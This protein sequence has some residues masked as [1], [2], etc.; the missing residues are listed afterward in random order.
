V[1]LSN[2]MR[3]RNSI[4]FVSIDFDSIRLTS[5]RFGSKSSKSS[6]KRNRI[7]NFF[8]IFFQIFMIRFGRIE[9]AIYLNS[10]RFNRFNAKESLS[11]SVEILPSVWFDSIRF[12]S[13]RFDSIR[14]DSVRFVFDLVRIKFESFTVHSLASSC[15]Y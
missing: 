5:I 4:R 13:V 7:F 8:L 9:L 12:D 1:K 14:F 2:L 15:P 10:I 3:T 11:F 6:A